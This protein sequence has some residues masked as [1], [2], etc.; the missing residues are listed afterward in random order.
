MTTPSSP[1]P[2]GARPTARVMIVPVTIETD[3]IPLSRLAP[4]SGMSVAFHLA[5]LAAFALLAPSSQADGPM[6]TKV[7]AVVELDSEDEAQRRPPFDTP[8]IGSDALFSGGDL[9]SNSRNKDVVDIP[10]FG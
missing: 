6:E 7:V 1:A 5:L 4:A 3:A 2:S 8:D 9:G 10:D